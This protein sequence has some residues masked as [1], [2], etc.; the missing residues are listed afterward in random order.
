MAETIKQRWYKKLKKDPERY[1]KSLV[2]AKNRQRD[3][4]HAARIGYPVSGQ[5]ECCGRHEGNYSLHY[6]HDHKTGAFRG[7]I[8]LQCNTAIGK[9]GD[10][11]DGV[12]NAVKYLKRS[13]DKIK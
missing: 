13:K 11:I 6:D 7:W 10:D 9:L 3:L 8:C 5:C 2:Y 12:L 4:R 1:A